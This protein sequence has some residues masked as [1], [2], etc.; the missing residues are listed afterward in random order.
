[1]EGVEEKNRQHPSQ[2]IKQSQINVTI[3]VIMGKMAG[4]EFN[5]KMFFP[6]SYPF[7]PP[8]V[9]LQPANDQLNEIINKNFNH[10][11]SMETGKVLLPIFTSEWNPVLDFSM[12]IFELQMFVS[13][14]SS[15]SNHRSAIEIHDEF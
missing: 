10:L 4:N 14:P 7:K 8:A 15:I 9:F 1:M 6:N 5:F 11:I 13:N 3:K 12:I 2:A